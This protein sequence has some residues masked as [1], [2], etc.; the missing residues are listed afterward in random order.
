MVGL[1]LI[2]IWATNAGAEMDTLGLYVKQVSLFWLWAPLLLLRKNIS[3]ICLF[4]KL[5]SEAGIGVVG[6]RGE[7]G[8]YFRT[9]ISYRNDFIYRTN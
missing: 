5:S 1:A 4:V 3:L 2:N 8:E 6:G 9:W 7:K